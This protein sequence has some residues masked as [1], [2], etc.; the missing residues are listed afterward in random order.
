[1]AKILVSFT[2]ILCLVFICWR[3]Y[4]KRNWLNESLPYKHKFCTIGFAV[5]IILILIQPIPYL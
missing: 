5:E 1:M 2:T 3:H 4:L